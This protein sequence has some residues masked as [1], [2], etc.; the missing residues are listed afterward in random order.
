M[1][2]FDFAGKRVGFWI[3]E[4]SQ[5]PLAELPEGIVPV[6]DGV[7]TAASRALVLTALE[8][9]VNAVW[10]VVLH[11]DIGAALVLSWGERLVAALG[12][13]ALFLDGDG[14]IC[15]RFSAAGD[16][17]VGGAT[18]GPALVLLGRRAL[19]LVE[20]DGTRRW[21]LALAADSALLLESSP[22]LLRLAAFSGPDW[23]ELAIDPVVGQILL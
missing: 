14:R 9:G 10:S 8:G 15:G 21:S 16:E 2:F 23:R 13:T 20:P 7:K 3:A 1:G 19:H 4:R 5:D 18:C 22:S 11:A 6:V 17:L 12:D